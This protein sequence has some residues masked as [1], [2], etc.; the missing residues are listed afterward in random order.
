MS[1]EINQIRKNK[2][3]AYSIHRQSILIHIYLLLMKYSKLKSENYGLDIKI[4]E[5]IQLFN[6]NLDLDTLTDNWQISIMKKSIYLVVL[7]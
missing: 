2:N 5:F 1:S 6:Q 7:C 4:G 3:R